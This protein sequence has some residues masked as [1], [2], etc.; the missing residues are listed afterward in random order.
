M[1]SFRMVRLRTD[2][3]VAALLLVAVALAGLKAVSKEEGTAVSLM[4]TTSE[5]ASMLASQQ[6]MPAGKKGPEIPDPHPDP[7]P[8]PY[9]GHPARSPRKEL[10]GIFLN[11][12]DKSSDAALAHEAPTHKKTIR[13]DRAGIVAEPTLGRAHGCKPEQITAFSLSSGAQDDCD[14]LAAVMQPAIDDFNKRV[15][16]EHGKPFAGVHWTVGDVGPDTDLFPYYERHGGY[17]GLGF[18]D[19]R[20]DTSKGVH[21]TLYKPT[22]GYERTKYPLGTSFLKTTKKELEGIFLKKLNKSLK[23]Y[24]SVDTEMAKLVA[25]GNDDLV[26][27]QTASPTNAVRLLRDATADFKAARAYKTKLVPSASRQA[28]EVAD[29]ILNKEAPPAALTLARQKALGA[30]LTSQMHRSTAE[31]QAYIDGLQGDDAGGLLLNTVGAISQEARQLGDVADSLASGS[32]DSLARVSTETL[33]VRAALAALD[34]AAS[35]M[36]NNL[37]VHR[38]G[39]GTF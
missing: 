26:R 16:E 30:A 29:G 9:P 5:I 20:Y 37:N 35:K 28:K 7:D 3:A 21:P 4:A 36:G 22:V 39:H 8:W 23:K 32:S 17:S 19:I 12:L 10:E 33:D 18:H 34:T 24:K 13:Q 27:S 25:E 15:Q 14:P 38:F 1:A 31:E 6:P 11:K 2:A